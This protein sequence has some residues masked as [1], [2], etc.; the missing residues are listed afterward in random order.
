MV[1]TIVCR[2]ATLRAAVA[3]FATSPATRSSTLWSPWIFWDMTL[4]HSVGL[5]FGGSSGPASAAWR[6]TSAS[7][8]V[9]A[10]PTVRSNRLSWSLLAVVSKRAIEASSSPTRDANRW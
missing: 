10:P 8:E 7:E 9:L 5:S 4:S 3:A 2:T 1:V 6:I